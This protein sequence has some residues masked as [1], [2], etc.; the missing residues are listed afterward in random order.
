ML[1][2]TPLLLKIVNKRSISSQQKMLQESVRDK[3]LVRLNAK[4]QKKILGKNQLSI[5]NK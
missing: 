1:W 4:H 3:I 2:V 5:M